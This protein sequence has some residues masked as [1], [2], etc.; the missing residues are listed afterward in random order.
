V[1]IR[2]FQWN[3]QSHEPPE[4]PLEV[5]EAKVENAVSA[6][7]ITLSISALQKLRKSIVSYFE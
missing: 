2:S 4:W 3:M 5:L 6:L 7:L 1:L